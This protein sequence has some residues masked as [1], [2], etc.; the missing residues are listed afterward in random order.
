M[1]DGQDLHRRVAR[2]LGVPL[3]LLGRRLGFVAALE[4]G[5]V[6]SAHT[7]AAAFRR[8]ASLLGNPLYSWYGHLWEA[9][10]LVVAGRFAA[11]EEELAR[12]D[13][14]GRLA[15][16]TNAEVLAT[17]LRLVAAWA[18]GDFAGAQQR[19]DAM[20]TD[21][22]DVAI[23]INAAGGPAWSAVLVGETAQGRHRLDLVA[24]QDDLA[25]PEDAEWLPS[26][27]NLVRAA[28]AL[29]HDV[30][31]RL[32]TALQP[33]SGLVA[34][35]GI[36]A[37]LYGSVARFVAIGCSAL[38]R[39]HDAVVA[40]EQAVEVNGRFGGLLEIEA[41]ETLAE[42]LEAAGGTPTDGRAARAARAE[43]DRLRAVW[44]GPATTGPVMPDAAPSFVR[45]GEVWRVQFETGPHHFK[46]SKGLADLAVLLA[47]PHHDVHVSELEGV[48]PPPLPTQEAIDRRAVAAYRA[49]LEELSA[50]M[51]AAEAAGDEATRQAAGTEY[52]ALVRHL[53]ASTGLGGRPR[54]VAPEPVERQRKAVSAR[55]RDAI[56]R[57]SLVDPT[58]GRH[59]ADAVRTGVRCSYEPRRDV[60][61]RVE[62]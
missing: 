46:H 61:W 41:A 15:G 28:A 45:E 24:R 60:E 12:V 25:T 9:Q 29:R 17:V 38:G 59:L 57:I 40:A 39:H 6:L 37:G 56:S 3:E 42:V 53:S 34:F 44:P 51:A 47:R 49:R 43:A 32:V 58:L 27:C 30:L 52:D 2:L 8:S 10:S 21:H 1:V 50:E 22:P 36:G 62:S 26:M 54:P 4:A 5:D 7:E 11:A 55:I 18:H 13:E 14:L 35:E 23:H 33:H 16:S 48:A 20:A 31:E 19:L